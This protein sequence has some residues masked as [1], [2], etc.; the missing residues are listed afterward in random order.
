MARAH[1][2]DRWPLD[3]AI[4][5]IL[6]GLWAAT[7]IARAFTPMG[8]AHFGD[9]MQAVIGG[10][11]FRGDSARM[12]TLAQAAVVATFAAGMLAR[13]RWSLA[14]ALF[15]LAQMVLSHLVF[16]LVYLD[17]ARESVYVRMAA[18]EGPTLVLITL[19]LWIRAQDVL[20]GERRRAH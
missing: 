18:F 10:I 3:L 6:A 8:L 19:Y 14:L 16:I 1:R 7:L 9:P 15:Y 4:F 5:A 17:D 12:V 20:F 11:K 2:T 13:R